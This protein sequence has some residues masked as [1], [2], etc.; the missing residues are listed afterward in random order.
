MV[1][2]GEAR[3]SEDR[4]DYCTSF[5]TVLEDPESCSI[6]IKSSNYRTYVPEGPAKTV[7]SRT[8]QPNRSVVVSA[9]GPTGNG[10]GIFYF[11]FI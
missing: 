8:N 4:P 7:R 1:I 10:K 3:K 11:I 6:L 5:T 2:I 9:P